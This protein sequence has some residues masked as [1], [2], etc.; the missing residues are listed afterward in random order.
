M[1]VAT[2][3]YCH[4]NF[5]LAVKDKGQRCCLNNS[6]CADKNNNTSLDIYGVPANLN[7]CVTNIDVGFDV[8]VFVL[9]FCLLV[10]YSKCKGTLAKGNAV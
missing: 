8:R 6:K 7:A 10:F 5:G 4:V 2:V 1:T 3:N 9:I